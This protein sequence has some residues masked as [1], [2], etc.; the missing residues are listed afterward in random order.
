MLKYL[1]YQIY[2]SEVPNELSLG[3][4]VLGCPQHCKGCHSSHTWDINCKGLGKDLTEDELDKMIA[5]QKEASCILFFGGDWDPS[6]LNK[7]LLHLT[8]Y[9]NKPIALYSGKDLDYLQRNIALVH[10][11][12]LKYG[13][14]QENLGGL[15][16]SSS[17]QRIYKVEN[18]H[19][20]ECLNK[21]FTRTFPS[22]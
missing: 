5:D 20:T 17:N 13:D 15:M 14:Y 4:T 16:N 6:Y 1:N 9:H 19:L 21:Y 11:S 2:P 12:Y 18:G 3:I 22:Y 10:L 7:L 8:I